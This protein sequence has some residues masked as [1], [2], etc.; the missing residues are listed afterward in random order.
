MVDAGSIDGLVTLAGVSRSPAP[1]RAD[2]QVV[3][4]GAG[5]SVPSG[6][7]DFGRLR[8][9]FLQPL[10][11]PGQAVPD[12]DAL[13][14]EQIFQLLDDGREATREQLRRAMW[15]ECENRSPGANHFAVARLG[16]AG[17]RIWTTNFDTL[18]ER[19]ASRLGLPCSVITSAE[20]LSALGD[21]RQPGRIHLVKLHGSFPF[22]G[23][24]PLRPGR[25]DYQLLFRSGDVWRQ[26]GEAW[27]DRLAAD[28]AGRS[29]A[30]FGYRGADL[31]VVPALLE[32]LP[33]AR[34]VS[35]WELPDQGANLARL[36]ERFGVLSEVVEIC[37]GDPS[38]ELQRLAER[39]A[40]GE[41]SRQVV[42]GPA[43]PAGTR[44][45]VATPRTW[46]AK[47]AVR[48]EFDGARAAR[49]ALL[50]AAVSDPPELQGP[51]AWRW[52]R[53]LA[54][55]RAWARGLF[56][57]ALRQLTRMPNLVD[58]K[59]TWTLLATMVDARPS[60]R[61]DTADLA[62]LRR[63]PFRDQAEILIRLA[64]KEKRAGELDQAA[65][66]L[67]RAAED[68][69]G[70]SEVLPLLE[71]MVAYNLIW[72][73]RQ[74]WRLDGRQRQVAEYRERMS[75]IGFNWAAWLEL[76]EVFLALNLGK[77]DRAAEALDGPFLKIAH[78]QIRH[79][80]YLADEAQARAL[81]GWHQEEASAAAEGLEHS[82]RLAESLG[83][84]GRSFTAV[85]DLILLA[86]L[87]R[88]RGREV[89]LDRYL[90]AARNRTRSPLQLARIRLV[91]AAAD[92]DG[93]TLGD[94]GEEARRRSWG[95][96]ARTAAALES[97][98]PSPGD[99]PM[100]DRNLPL[101]A[102]Y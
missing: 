13:S 68:L 53:S 93:W 76:E 82:Q 94:L 30:F 7:P 64:S 45:E 43:E 40:P 12:P 3:F 65:S 11:R 26:L 15:E 49:M 66:D 50:R 101:P 42:L 51:A 89:E 10:L 5:I 55:D 21:D 60:S 90:K 34:R 2:S 38:A 16:A 77:P 31:D 36:R 8:D 84:G 67:G 46:T 48:G 91:R 80:M 25:H 44:I 95:L 33:L 85:D 61:R 24:P 9:R 81:L 96:M 97:A 6:A 99:Q 4:V 92:G 73:E 86:D 63:C 47:A 62:L 98:E 79:P 39:L 14:P 35:W 27:V 19:A 59:L 52:L 1:A 41:P 78:E 22:P 70:R 71:A 56:V 37:P 23:D 72:I 57:Y 100:V 54:Y 28:M 32:T 20:A 74:R 69:A 83:G 75:H 87:A 58:P 18:I 17:V 88:V 102:L 29:V